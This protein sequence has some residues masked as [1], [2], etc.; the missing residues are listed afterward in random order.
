M[1]V[2]EV[3]AE[4][5]SERGLTIEQASAATRIRAEHLSALESDEP[6]RL[7]APVYARGYLRTYARYLGLDPEPLVDAL[8]PPPHDARRALELGTVASRPRV[9]LT[10]RA[11]A[12]AGLVLLAAMFAVYAWRQIE[13]GQRPGLGLPGPRA[14]PPPGNPRPS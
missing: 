1:K 14:P 2:G 13:S 11:A 3:L 4:T 12:A 10:A 9:V 7:P 8:R 6:G 5:R